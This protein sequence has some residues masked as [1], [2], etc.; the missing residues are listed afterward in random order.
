MNN[1]EGT[2][3]ILTRFLEQFGPEVQGRE[4][5]QPPEE[6]QAQL[7]RLAKGDLPET[8][9]D[10]VFTLLRRNPE[11]TAWLAQEV[12]GLRPSGA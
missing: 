6:V 5:A 11:W 9:Q 12:K 7:R 3:E 1:M 8:E 10:T 2:F 4:T